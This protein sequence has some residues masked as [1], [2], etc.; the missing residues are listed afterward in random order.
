MDA[1]AVVGG[2][3][4]ELAG[5]GAQVGLAP[6]QGRGELRK[7]PLL[8]LDLGLPRPQR[9]VQLLDSLASAVTAEQAL[10]PA[11]RA[12]GRLDGLVEVVARGVL[13][14]GQLGEPAL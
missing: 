2:G 4:L 13:L 3:A 9:L 7:P 1:R 12:G 14:L 10:A 6:L 5:I 11:A 8:H